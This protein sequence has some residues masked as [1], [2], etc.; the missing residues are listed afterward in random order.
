MTRWPARRWWRTASPRRTCIC[1]RR[2][3]SSCRSRVL[4]GVEDSPSG[5]QSAHAA[6]M[7][8]AMVPDQDQP[9]AEIAALCALVAPS[10]AG[11]APFVK[12]SLRRL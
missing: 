11:I 4:L 12:E 10:L 3:S 1:W 8:V 6:G 9:S 7:T 5:V 2:R